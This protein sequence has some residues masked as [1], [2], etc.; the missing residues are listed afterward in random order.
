VPSNWRSHQAHRTAGGAS[1]SE[2]ASVLL[3]WFR[4]PSV[5]IADDNGSSSSRVLAVEVKA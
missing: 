3:V 4:L 1:I 5:R 2:Y